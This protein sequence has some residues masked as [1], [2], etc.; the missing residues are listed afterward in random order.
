MEKKWWMDKTIYQIYPKSFC[1]SNGDGIGDIPGIIGKL[2]Y[3]KNLGVD[4]LWISP[5]YKSPFVD[6]GYDISDYYAIDPCFGTM[7]DMERLILETKKRG[8]YIIMDLVVNHCSSEHPWFQEACRNPDGESGTFFYIRDAGNDGR[9][10]NWRS[11]FGGSAW[12]PLPGHPDKVYLHSFHEKQPDLNWENPTVRKEIYRM[13]NWWLEKGLSGFRADAILNIKKALPMRNYEPD[14]DDGLCSMET[15]LHHAEGLT[16]FLMEMKRETFDRFDAFSVAEVSG[17][18][19]AD[20]PLYLGENGCFSSMFDFHEIEIGRTEKGC[21]DWKKP[22]PDDYKNAAFEAQELFNRSGFVT[23]V[24]ENHDTPRGVNHFIPEG[25]LN[26]A[27]KKM[28]G[29]LNFFLR[30]IPCIYQGQELGMENIPLV[31]PDDMD[32][33]SAINEYRVALENGLSPS[34]AL[35]AVAQYSR[36]NARTPMQWDTTHAAG[37][38]TGTPWMK[39]NPN[40]T[41]I[42]AQDEMSDP[43]SVYT[44]YRKMLALRKSPE[45]HETL[46]YGSF[47]P[48]W[49]DEPNLMAYYRQ[50]DKR[51]LVA[52]NYTSRAREITLETSLKKVLL[53]NYPEIRQ[54]GNKL[55]LEG[56]QVLVLEVL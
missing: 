21:Y 43:S 53:N 42:N 39:V 24:I 4:I 33:I 32:D 3:L 16:D 6:Q 14:R 56:Y 47:E 41:R 44:F 55:L 20:I 51:I 36:D 29:T 18:Q 46:V 23:N 34:E 13:M 40:Y 28:L 26:A 22:A 11:Y 54:S 27:G 35:H 12:S 31:S 1:D 49:K 38:S 9:P 7:E 25:E 8:L 37:F 45:Y 30:G 50:A 15:M 10:T 19:D 2:D 48:V 17:E 52:G 5:C